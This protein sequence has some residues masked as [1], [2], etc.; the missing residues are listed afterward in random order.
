META[1]HG[2]A[3]VRKGLP[4]F[5]RRFLV[6]SFVISLAL[7]AKPAQTKPNGR[8]ATS[9]RVITVDVPISEA[10]NAFLAWLQLH[11]EAAPQPKP[12]IPAP[13]QG[14]QG[15]QKE[16]GSKPLMIQTPSI[17]LYS[18]SG[19]S[20]YHGTD[21]EK[22]AAF[23]RDL[24]RSIREVKRPETND[25][26]PT[27][28]EIVEM[29]AELKPYEADILA[30]KQDTIFALTLFDTARCKAQNDAMQE[31]RRQPSEVGVRIVEVRLH[32]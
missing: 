7:S 16:S 5:D 30:G 25:I 10:G 12:I 31:L 27:L 29:F 28:K 13:S 6:L 19:V 17:D 24:P 26:R 1:C 20:L 3:E 8:A 14:L 15:P 11:P 23:I 4:L 21:S 2:H 22:N 18:P 32:L 9:T